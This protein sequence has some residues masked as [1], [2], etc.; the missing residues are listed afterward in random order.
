MWN[1]IIY[2]SS[3]SLSSFHDETFEQV[4]YVKGL[5]IAGKLFINKFYSRK[6][7]YWRNAMY[8][9]G[10]ALREVGQAS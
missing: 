7:Y 8:D 6:R 4:V 9:A 2:P 3:H 5:Q 1:D 10:W